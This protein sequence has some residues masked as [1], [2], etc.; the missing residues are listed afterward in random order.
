MPATRATEPRSAPSAG[1]RPGFPA[2][3]ARGPWS[4][5]PRIRARRAARCRSAHVGPG[6]TARRG[7]WDSRRAPN[8]GRITPHR[9]VSLPFGE[10]RSR[11]RCI[12]EDRRTRRL[13]RAFAECGPPFLSRARHDASAPRYGAIS[14]SESA[15]RVGHS[16]WRQARPVATARSGAPPPQRA[17]YAA[18]D[19]AHTRI[20]YA[21]RF[22]GVSIPGV[23]LGGVNVRAARAR[24]MTARMVVNCWHANTHESVAM[25][26]LYTT[27]GDG[28]AIGSRPCRA[29]KPRLVQ[30]IYEGTMV[31]R[32]TKHG[33]SLALVID[34]PI[35][36]LLKIDTETPLDLS[37]DGHR[38]IVAPA[39]QS[40]RR[41]KFETA[42]RTAHKRYGKAFKK[43]AE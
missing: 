37:T 8:H 19:A 43:L 34:R 4:A 14:A 5:A 31:K 2:R 28:V 35:L 10:D 11:S 16:Q 24:S 27:G 15:G 40:E 17:S 20:A 13:R 18:L 22:S 21:I 29:C 26:K 36:D 39:E 23:R 33:N 32:L 12:V 30:W 42:Q 3:G 9:G 41:Q 1:R 7:A 25:W 38:L 6:S